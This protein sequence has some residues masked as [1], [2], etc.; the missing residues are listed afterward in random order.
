MNE[1]DPI[2]CPRKN[3]GWVEF[4]RQAF[5]I[6]PS[7]PLLAFEELVRRWQGCTV[8]PSC[9]VIDSVL[10]ATR[11]NLFYHGAAKEEFLAAALEFLREVEDRTGTRLDG[12]VLRRFLGGGLDPAHTSKIVTGLDLRRNR[13]DSRLKIWFMLRDYPEKVEAASAIHGPD[14][15]LGPLRVSGDFLVGFDLRMDG[16]TSIKLYPSVRSEELRNHVLRER[17]GR[18]LSPAAL[19]A[20]DYCRWTHLYLARNHAGVVLQ[21][22][23]ESPDD[24]VSG[25]ISHPFAQAIHALYRAARLLDMVVSLPEEDLVAGPIRRYTLYYMPA[26]EVRAAPRS[27]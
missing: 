26:D 17:L 21:F 6:D 1:T 5:A 12:A 14:D 27:T 15:R 8:E 22:H 9:A 13:A 24:F 11:F 23:P 3:A 25:M 19:H 4:H 10:Y 2:Y 18:V 16:H 20:M 7:E